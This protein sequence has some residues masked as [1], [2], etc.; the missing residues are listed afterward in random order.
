MLCRDKLSE[1]QFY[2]DRSKDS[3]LA[4]L[5]S[6]IS[7]PRLSDDDRMILLRMMSD[8]HKQ[9]FELIDARIEQGEKKGVAMAQARFAASPE[10]KQ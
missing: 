6:V 4:T 5:R 7:N 3:L 9:I 10:A 8:H 1:V 2:L